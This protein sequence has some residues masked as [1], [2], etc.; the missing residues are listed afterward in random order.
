MKKKSRPAFVSWAVRALAVF[1]LI[2]AATF[3]F[4]RPDRPEK[5]IEPGSSSGPAFRVQVIRPR[6]GLPLGG[7]LPPRVFGLDARLSFDSESAGAQV[8]QSG[9][10]RIEL[11]ADDWRLVL[12]MNA[13][14]EVT[15]DS[16]IEFSM[17]FEDQPR[18]VR[19]RPADPVVGEIVVTALRGGA[20]LGGHFEIELAHCEDAATGQSLGWPPAP[21][22]L[23]GSFDRLVVPAVPQKG[24]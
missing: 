9:P 8:V 11:A 17:V 5:F 13:E 23:R 22:V 7:L 18:N 1:V 21:V 20:E 14:G 12:V 24:H 10:R 16:R 4:Y 6:A 19:C 2:I 3:I 15:A